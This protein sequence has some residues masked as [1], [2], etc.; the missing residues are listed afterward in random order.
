MMAT[1]KKIKRELRP[2]IRTYVE[3]HERDLIKQTAR[4]A[5]LTVSQ[6]VRECINDRL[7]EESDDVPLLQ[8]RDVGRPPTVA[9]AVQ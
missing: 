2:I 7:A 5:G 9:R 4:R 1:P 6:F 3:A 8:T